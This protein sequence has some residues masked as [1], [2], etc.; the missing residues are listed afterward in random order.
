M[1]QPTA[2]QSLFMRHLALSHFYCLML[3]LQATAVASDCY[4]DEFHRLT[5]IDYGNGTIIEYTYDA[6]GNRQT[7]VVSDDRSTLTITADPPDGGTVTGAGRFVR[8]SSRALSATPGGAFDFVSWN[9]ADGTVL[10]TNPSYSHL[11]TGDDSLIARFARVPAPTITVHPAGGQL[12]LSAPLTLSVTAS[13]R[14]PFTYLW[15]RNGNPLSASTATLSI[16]NPTWLDAGTYTVE[17]SNPGGTTLSQG[18]LIIIPITSYTAW[19]NVIFTPG[20]IAEN[21]PALIGPWAKIGSDSMTNLLH[22]ALGSRSRASAPANSFELHPA[23]P[24]LGDHLFQYNRLIGGGGFLSYRV[25][26]SS[27]LKAWDGSETELETAA[28][29]SLNSDGLTERLSLRLKTASPSVVPRRR[30]FRLDVLLD[31]VSIPG[32][33]FQMGNSMDPNEGFWTELPVHS[34]TL[35]PFFMDRYEVTKQTWDQVRVWAVAHGYGFQNIGS[36]KGDR[37]PVHSINWYDMVKWCNA[38]S[39]MEGLQ[40]VYFT[41][42]ACMNVYRSGQVSLSNAGVRWDAEGYR[43]PTEAEWEKSARG[44]LPSLRF[45]W[46]NTITHLQANYYSHA[47]NIQWGDVSATR[48]YHPAYSTDTAP[49]TSPVGSFAANAYGLYDMAGN[50]WESCW[51][52]GDGGGQTYY[53]DCPSSDPPGAEY[54]ANRAMR[55]GAW[56]DFIPRVSGR[57]IALPGSASNNRGFRCVRR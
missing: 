14:T 37:H 12:A 46:G 39:E 1:I 40:P 56:T 17:V 20:E 23:T 54:G 34:V 52:W 53:S 31:M 22:F 42:A 8:N 55:G 21:D 33:S 27:D 50:V 15:R 43:L 19:Q 5:R 13:G 9:R 18:A 44:S 6:G 57:F 26:V 2:K 51:D 16:P 38:R 49:Y 41:D 35:H 3:L 45:P 11:L 25:S 24:S 10:S 36:G 32:G 7:R 4:Y 30:F 47:N 28:P 29:P 48:G